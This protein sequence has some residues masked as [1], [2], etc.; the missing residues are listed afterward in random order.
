MSTNQIQ[1][2]HSYMYSYSSD[3]K[4]TVPSA[5][6]EMTLPRADKDLLIFLASSKTSPSAPVLLTY[7]VNKCCKYVR[8]LNSNDVQVLTIS[9]RRR[10]D[11]KPIFNEPKAK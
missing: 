10:G 11:Y 1:C 6:A 7:V 3:I 5:R 8:S 2:L 9:R 4:H